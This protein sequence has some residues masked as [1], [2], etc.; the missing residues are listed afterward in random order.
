MYESNFLWMFTFY[1]VVLVASSLFIHNKTFI[2][3]VRCTSFIV[4][5]GYL[6]T[7]I[8]YPY[9]NIIKFYKGVY[10]THAPPN[11]IIVA[12]DLLAHVA[13]F[14]IFGLPRDPNI[15]FFAFAVVATWY[16]VIREQ[17]HVIYYHAIEKKDIVYRDV[18]V[19]IIGPCFCVLY[20]FLR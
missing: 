11:E 14:T 6:I 1:N 2:E 7:I 15:L 8:A 10:K 4:L 13:P 12:I 9:S 18:F 19:Y 20:T 5:I 3:F 16:T 17:C